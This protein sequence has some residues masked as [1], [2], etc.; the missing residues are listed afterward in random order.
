VALDLLDEIQNYRILFMDANFWQPYVAAAMEQV[1]LPCKV[2]RGGN[3]GTCPTFIVDDAYVIKF[4]G[5]LFDGENSFNA[6]LYANGL[7][8]KQGDFPVPALVA[9][10]KL[11]EGDF[12]WKWPYLIFE[13][14]D[15][16]SLGE[17]W[18]DLSLAERQ[19]VSSEM[20]LFVGALHSYSLGENSYFV[21]N[22][23]SFLYFL[24]TQQSN[25]L[26]SMKNSG[27]LPFHLW[28]Q[29][30]AFLLPLDQLIDLKRKPYL[31]HADLTR[32]HIFGKVQDGK[33]NTL[34]VIDFG[35]ARVGNLYYELIALHLDLFQGEKQ[36][37]R[38][39]L[40]NYGFEMSSDNNF[41]KKAMNMTLLHQ[42]GENILTDLFRRCP[43]LEQIPTLDELAEKI[44]GIGY[45]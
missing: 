6:E 23:D 22:W 32:D 34:G 27:W 24:V 35:D 10:G 19:A 11:F 17:A 16:I 5:R 31:I 28:K 2:L 39:F 26:E 30:D 9:Q 40:E 14:L 7:V 1:E 15:G 37:L 4:Y 33:W 20:G 38:V 25:L 44:W 8:K 29:L 41:T 3:P 36:L 43:H 45:L 13:Y 18:G 42:F 21:P 12:H